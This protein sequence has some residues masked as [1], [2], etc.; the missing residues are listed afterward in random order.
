M[1]V[2]ADSEEFL[3]Q[4]CLVVLNCVYHRITRGNSTDNSVRIKCTNSG[5]QQDK[6]HWMYLKN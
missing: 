5:D 2:I 6:L 1:Y 4:Y 3:L